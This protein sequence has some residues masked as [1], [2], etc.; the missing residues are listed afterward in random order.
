[1]TADKVPTIED[2]PRADVEGRDRNERDDRDVHAISERGERNRDEQSTRMTDGATRT[3]VSN[4]KPLTTSK[5]AR[6]GKSS[7]SAA[8]AIPDTI[9]DTIPGTIR[10]VIRGLPRAMSN[11]DS[12][13]MREAADAKRQSIEPRRTPNARLI[14]AESTPTADIR[15]PPNRAE[16]SR[17]QS[18]RPSRRRAETEAVAAVEGKK[19]AAAKSRV[20]SPKAGGKTPP[21]EAKPETAARNEAKPAK[22]RQTARRQGTRTRKRQKRRFGK[23]RGFRII[24]SDRRNIAK[25]GT[26]A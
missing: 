2:G 16:A 24:V 14:D 1:M 12:T 15:M 18:N 19:A 10:G 23:I 20:G 21:A 22:P 25:V 3:N 26:D 6:T 9:L 4:A 5:T 7:T 17:N 8:A 13:M 11:L